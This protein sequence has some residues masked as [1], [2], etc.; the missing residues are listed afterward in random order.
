M[1]GKKGSMQFSRSRRAMAISA[2][3]L[4]IMVNAALRLRFADCNRQRGVLSGR[5]TRARRA[6]VAAD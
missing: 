2:S 4:A 5:V 6:G 1:A 3:R